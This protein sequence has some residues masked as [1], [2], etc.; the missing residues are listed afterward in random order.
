MGERFRGSDENGEYIIWQD[1]K[2]QIN[3]KYISGPWEGTHL[4]YDPNT[5]RH[6]ASFGE[7]SKKTMEDIINGRKFDK[8]GYPN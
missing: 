3:K 4:Y 1:A 2:G 8:D 6:G 7:L 5:T